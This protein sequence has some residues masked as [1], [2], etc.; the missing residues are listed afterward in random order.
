[1]CRYKSS[2][3]K[4]ESDVIGPPSWCVPTWLVICLLPL[5][6]TELFLNRGYTLWFNWGVLAF[7]FTRNDRLCQFLAIQGTGVCLGWYSS[8]VVEHILHGTIFHLLYKNS[9]QF[10]REIIMDDDTM[11]QTWYALL[12]RAVIHFFDLLAHP[13]LTI[14]CWRKMGSRPLALSSIV[15][16]YGCSRAWSLLHSFYNQQSFS[17]HYVGHDVYNVNDLRLWYPAY[18]AEYVWHGLLLLEVCRRQSRTAKKMSIDQD[19]RPPLLS[20]SESG[21]SVESFLLSN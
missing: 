18:I 10:L 8:V 9:P 14:W 17:F 15:A 7:F 6:P 2:K 20:Q 3:I 21:L 11:V 1:M 19:S 12:F 13:L 4:S 16:S 5:M